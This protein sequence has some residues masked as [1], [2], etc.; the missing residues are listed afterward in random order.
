MCVAAGSAVTSV[1]SLLKLVP[2]FVD[3]QRYIAESLLFPL[4]VN[5]YAPIRIF[6]PPSSMNA[7]SRNENAQPVGYRLKRNDAFFV[8][9]GT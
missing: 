6:P 5:E 3:F 4:P 9:A 7:Q 2:P 1:S 8:L